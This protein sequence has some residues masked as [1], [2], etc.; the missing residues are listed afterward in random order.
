MS[1]PASRTR[2][3]AAERNASIHFA[4]NSDSSGAMNCDEQ[5]YRKNGLSAGNPA[6][7][8]NSSRVVLG[9][10][11]NHWSYTGA[12][13]TTT[14]PGDTPCIVTASFFWVSFHTNT[15]SGS[16][17]MRPLFVRLSQLCTHSPDRTP[18][19]FAALMYSTWSEPT[20]TSGVTSTTSGAWLAIVSATQRSTGITYSIASRNL[21]TA[22]SPKRVRTIGSARKAR[23][24]AGTLMAARARSASA[25]AYSGVP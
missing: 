15:R 14:D 8:Q 13:V 16:T 23:N 1:R 17:R 11:A 25:R 9:R 7:R 6:L 21:E 20:S 18:S 5:R 12:P 22:R 3:S 4:M 10:R 19:A 2:G 24:N